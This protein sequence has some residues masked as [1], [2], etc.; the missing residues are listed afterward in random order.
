[1][2]I[3]HDRSGISPAPL[4]HRGFEVAKLQ[5]LCGQ[6]VAEPMLR[7]PADKHCRLPSFRDDGARGRSLAAAPHGDRLGGRRASDRARRA[8]FHGIEGRLVLAAAGLAVV[9]IGQFGVGEEKWAFAIVKP[10]A[11][12][13]IFA[14]LRGRK[15][16][17]RRRHRAA[18]LGLVEGDL[19]AAG[20]KNEIAQPAAV[21]DR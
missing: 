21:E 13:Q 10:A 5:H 19:F 4:F 6:E 20:R 2:R 9:R 17:K 11:P 14:K 16:M 7:H 1:M 12:F 15:G 18:V 8:S 3:A